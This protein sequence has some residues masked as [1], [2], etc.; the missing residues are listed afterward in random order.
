VIKSGDVEKM[1]EMWGSIPRESFTELDVVLDR[2]DG[3]NEIGGIGSDEI[4]PSEIVEM[5]SRLFQDEHAFPYYLSFVEL[6]M[7]Y[8]EK[9]QDLKSKLEVVHE[10]I[11]NNKVVHAFATVV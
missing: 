4:V 5:C 6:F 8:N 11:E 9:I 2:F 1:N 7:V 10:E 3:L